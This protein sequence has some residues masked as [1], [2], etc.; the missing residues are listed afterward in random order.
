M[1]LDALNRFVRF[2][3]QQFQQTN[4]ASKS[5]YSLRTVTE[6]LDDHLNTRTLRRNESSYSLRKPN[7]PI[8]VDYGKSVAISIACDI[9]IE[10]ESIGEE[11]ITPYATFT[12]KPICGMDTTRSLMSVPSVRGPDSHSSNSIE[13]DILLKNLSVGLLKPVFI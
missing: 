5:E 8:T 11:D 10:P 13:G 9:Y 4:P 6:Q 12:L 1:Q 2:L 3:R 7:Q